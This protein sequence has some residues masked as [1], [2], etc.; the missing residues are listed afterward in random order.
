MSSGTIFAR[1]ELV[2]LRRD[3]VVLL[4]LGCLALAIIVS[5]TVAS[6]D[7]RAQLADYHAYVQQLIESG[8]TVT[9]TVPRL[10]PLQLLRAGIE[11][12][13]IIGALFAIIIG[14]ATIARERSRGTLELLMTRE[15]GRFS[16]AGGK[17]MGIG[18]F[19]LIVVMGLSLVA[20]ATMA[21]VGTAHI[22]PGDLVRVGI[23]GVFAWLYLMFW[24]G[25]ALA[26]TGWFKRP[27][28]ALIV[29]LVLWL[30]FVLIVPQIG[31]TMDPDNQVPGGLFAALQIQKSDELAVLAHFARFDSL[32][33]GLEV[34]SIS[35]LYERITF[36][37][38]GIKDKYNQQ[39]LAF[40]WAD[41]YHYVIA[42][43]AMTTAAMGLALASGNRRSIL[44]KAS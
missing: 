35:K 23:A 25:L 5:V 36:A 21:V 9:P 19:W 2:D 8:S 39:S 34:S 20:T 11:Y 28:T 12:L 24:S 15:V 17:L 32:R 40:V 13:E 31:D 14:Y 37:F 29:A 30:I 3:R 18:A 1:K 41:M 27:T 7:F 22:S 33:N 16:F 42:V 43:F 38:L 4:L 6:L 26:L 10:F 44:R